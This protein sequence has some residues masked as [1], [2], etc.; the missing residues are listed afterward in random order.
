M[1]KELKRSFIRTKDLFYAPPPDL[2][3]LAGAE[4]REQTGCAPLK[5]GIPPHVKRRDT[6]KL[7]R[8]AGRIT[9]R[10]GRFRES[11]SGSLELRLRLHLLLGAPHGHRA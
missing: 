8:V 4:E 9:L 5:A 11:S 10:R 2:I 3:G 1:N 6:G 7:A